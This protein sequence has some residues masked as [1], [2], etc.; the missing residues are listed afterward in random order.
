M[1][2]RFKGDLVHEGVSIIKKGKWLLTPIPRM[3]TDGFDLYVIDSESKHVLQL[4]S[5]MC[6][7]GESFGFR[8]EYFN[9]KD[10]F[11]NDIGTFF[12]VPK[13]KAWVFTQW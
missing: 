5:C 3:W 10:I 9:K 11:T 12:Y 1:I 8:L 2:D 4:T 13:K 6:G 7:V